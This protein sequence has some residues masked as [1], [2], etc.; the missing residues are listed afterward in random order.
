MEQF[1]K[2]RSNE[3]FGCVVISSCDLPQQ[4][5]GKVCPCSICIVK[6]ICNIGMGCNLYGAYSN[7]IEDLLV[8]DYQHGLLQEANSF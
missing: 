7:Y 1:E 2:S 3:C 6:P 4:Y 5:N 8:N